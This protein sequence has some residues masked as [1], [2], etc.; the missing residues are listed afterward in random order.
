MANRSIQLADAV[1]AAIEAKVTALAPSYTVQAKRQAAPPS[2]DP[3]SLG[4]NLVLAITPRIQ[5]TERI[6]RDVRLSEQ[7]QIEISGHRRTGTDEAKIEA[8]LDLLQSLFDDLVVTGI[9][10]TSAAVVGWEW[11]PIADE[12]ELKRNGV[13]RSVALIQVN[14]AAKAT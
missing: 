5:A 14:E 7:T 11:D 12:E 8:V 2:Y 3:R 6:G 4:D 10:I 1:K 9:S 13:L